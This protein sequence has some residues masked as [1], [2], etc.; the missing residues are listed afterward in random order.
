MYVFY[1]I[2]IFRS[3]ITITG[4]SD[5]LKPRM[6]CPGDA[7]VTPKENTRPAREA[8]CKMP[9]ANQEDYSRL[10]VSSTDTLPIFSTA[11]TL[12]TL[13]NPDRVMSTS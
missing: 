13:L 2:D 1:R 8:G 4:Q 5:W 12:W 11:I 10:R 6:G 3:V 7:A 9:S